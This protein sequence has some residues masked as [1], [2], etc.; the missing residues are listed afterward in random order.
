MKEELRRT[1]QKVSKMQA[2]FDKMKNAFHEY[3]LQSFQELN[4]KQQALM[5]YFPLD[6]LGEK[7]DF[8]FTNNS[9]AK[10]IAKAIFRELG[11][12]GFN[13]PSLMDLVTKT[14]K[15]C[16][17]GELRAQLHIVKKQAKE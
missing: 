14:A 7:V 6:T 4:D 11:C 16:F 9:T 5:A 8:L 17:S 13:R 10:T 15:K 2:E 3:D 1:N 12:V